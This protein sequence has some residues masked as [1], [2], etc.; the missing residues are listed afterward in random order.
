MNRR[1]A[2]I[3]AKL[4]ADPVLWNAKI[5][6]LRNVGLQ[7]LE[8]VKKRNAAELWVHSYNL[9]QACESC[10]LQSPGIRETRLSLNEWIASCANWAM[11]NRRRPAKRHQVS[12]RYASPPWLGRSRPSR[13]PP[14]ED[15]LFVDLT[16]L[17]RLPTTHVPD[18]RNDPRTRRQL[19]AQ[20]LP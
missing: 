2:Q 19:G 13:D 20:F 1:P 3:E 18:V 15:L 5:E 7:V 12:R 17:G 11:S 4:E 10:H 14:Q 9:D 16:N 8:I 6:A